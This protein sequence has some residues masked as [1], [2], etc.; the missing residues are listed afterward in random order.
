MSHCTGRGSPQLKE[1]KAD[2]TAFPF[3]KPIPQ[4]LKLTRRVQPL[5]GPLVRTRTL[6]SDMQL[7]ALTS[8][9]SL[10][11]IRFRT[12]GTFLQA[13]CVRT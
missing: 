1:R 7:P 10:L 12:S 13:A 9:T 8:K 11:D 2:T 5:R 4:L 6:C 3:M